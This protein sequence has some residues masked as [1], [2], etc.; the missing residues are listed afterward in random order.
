MATL[1]TTNVVATMFQDDVTLTIGGETYDLP[2]N[3]PVGIPPNVTSLTTDIATKALCRVEM[4]K[5]HQVGETPLDVMYANE[6]RVV[7]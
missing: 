4:S 5:E 2:A 3:V 6:I 7:S 1:D